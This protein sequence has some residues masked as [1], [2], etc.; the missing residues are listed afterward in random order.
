MTQ[1]IR[2]GH[3]AYTGANRLAIVSGKSQAIHE[4]RCRGVKRDD[5]RKAVKE[6]IRGRYVDVYGGVFGWEP[7]EVQPQVRAL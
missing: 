2:I 7:V 5:A 3:S 1:G 6:A 4:L